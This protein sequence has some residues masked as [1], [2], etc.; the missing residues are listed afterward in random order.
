MPVAAAP[1]ASTSSLSQIRLPRQSGT[2]GDVLAA[3]GLAELLLDS[4]HDRG[5]RIVDEGTAFLVAMSQPRSLSEPLPVPLI[6]GYRYLRVATK[7]QPNPPLPDGVRQPHDYQQLKEQID[8]LRKQEQALFD[9]RKSGRSVDQEALDDLQRQWPIA[10][11]LW[12]RL[13]ALLV[14]QGHE[15]ANKV[16]ATI[17]QTPPDQFRGEI[18]TALQALVS[19]RPS[20]LNWPVSTVQLFSPLAAKGYARLKPDSTARGDKTKDA[21]ADPFVEW[22]RYRGYFSSVTPVFYGSQGE[23]IRLLCP[24]PGDIALTAYQKVAQALPPP[25]RGAGPP[26]IDI[27]AGLALARLLIERSQEFA[28][29][30]AEVIPDL[31]MEDKTPAEVISGLA[32][33]NFQSLGQA[34]AVSAL[35][36]LAL[37]GW[38]RV[39]SQQDAD[40]WLAILEEHRMIVRGLQDSHSDEFTLLQGYRRFLERRG[41]R[42]LDALLDF[43]GAYGQFVLRAREAKRRVRQFGRKHFRRVVV[44]MN[45]SYA[46]ILDDDGFQAVAAAVRRAT[47]NAQTLKSQGKDHRE[48]R[49][50]L[51]P[52]LRRTRELPGDKSFLTALAD[53][54]SLYNAEN[55]RRAEATR[56]RP[57]AARISTE[58]F[59]AFTRL[60][61]TNHADVVGALL[62]AY[63]TCTERFEPTSTAD[64]GSDEETGGDE[65]AVATESEES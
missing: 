32:I 13:V 9:A 30:G 49:Y 57:W 36:E 52:E 22:L 61:D 46:A 19:G 1:P 4:T 20:G 33:T 5:I 40:E 31:Q 12:R 63:G 7:K 53:F 37:P 65:S 16:Y 44:A 43:A 42:A 48:I 17:V 10:R 3:V 64:L 15:T 18:Q 29:P 14:L 62:C 58:Q 24:V 45:D 59:A 60:V 35:G 23:H 21:W 6:P 28:A 27:L 38:F 39:R 8:A 25:P 41:Q 51:L 54:V 34:R 2:H 11:D 55:S 26:K 47:V 50:G 56:G